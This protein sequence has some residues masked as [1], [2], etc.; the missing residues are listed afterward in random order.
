[1]E[2]ELRPDKLLAHPT[3]V[4]SKGY[5]A[6][7]AHAAELSGGRNGAE[8]L[9]HSEVVAD[10]P[11]LGDLA[12]GKPVDEVPFGDQAQRRPSRV[13][14]GPHHPLDSPAKD[15]EAVFGFAV[16]LIVR[17]VSADKAVE[18]DLAGRPLPPS[19]TR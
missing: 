14:H 1:L 18:V 17:N 9:H 7:G 3:L 4:L 5:A 2:P 8:L 6:A 16:G 19:R 11:V 13:W 15:I 10:D 12:V